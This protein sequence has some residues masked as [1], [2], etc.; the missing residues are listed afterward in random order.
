MF[1][2][3]GESYFSATVSTAFQLIE[4]LA[5]PG[6]SVPQ[7]SVVYCYMTVTL[8]PQ[9]HYSVSATCSLQIHCQWIAL[10]NG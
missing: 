5:A 1:S 7:N 4:R 3:T 9:Q 10:L 2:I 6:I 8:T